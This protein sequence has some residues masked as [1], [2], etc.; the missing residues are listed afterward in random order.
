MDFL[1][2]YMAYGTPGT[3]ASAEVRMVQ[4]A[5][6]VDTPE[7]R[8]P[9]EAGLTWE[10][11]DDVGYLSLCEIGEGE[12]VHQK[13]VKNPVRGAPEIILDFDRSSRLLGIEFM[14]AAALPPSLA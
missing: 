5:S 1:A 10:S 14:G 6:M 2:A 12:A 3:N 7:S 13:I 4:T 8:R 11:E 9:V